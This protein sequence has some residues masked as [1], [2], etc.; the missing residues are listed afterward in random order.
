MHLLA[1]DYI[2]PSCPKG[3]KKYWVWL[4]Q[5]EE[6]EWFGDGRDENLH[7]RFTS[8]QSL[9]TAVKNGEPVVD[10]WGENVEKNII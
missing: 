8:L 3:S 10:S 5:K 7:V 4:N 9:Q 2:H 6:D 1:L